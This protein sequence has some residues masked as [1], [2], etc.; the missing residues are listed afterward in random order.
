MPIAPTPVC[1]ASRQRYTG[2]RAMGRSDRAPV[3]SLLLWHVISEVC[4]ATR[5]G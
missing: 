5:G 2:A 4:Q 3:A 1:E